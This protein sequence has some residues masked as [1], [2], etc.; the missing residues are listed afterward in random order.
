[1]GILIN[2]GF[3]VGSSNPIDS[4][5]L[6]ETTLER[7]ALISDGLV[8]ENLKVYCKDT[9]TEYRWTGTEWEISSSSSS[10]GTDI[11]MTDYYTKTEVDN[12]FLKK[13]D[14]ASTYATKTDIETMSSIILDSEVRLDKTYS[15]SKIYTDIQDAIDTSKAYTLSELGKMSGASYKVVTATSEMTDEKI[16]Y[17]LD[18]GTTF[19]MYIV[20]SGIPTKIGDTDID[21]SEYYTKTEVDNDFLKKTDASSIYATK[22][23]LNEKANDDEVVKK[24]D[25]TDLQEQTNDLQEQIDN[26]T[27]EAYQSNIIEGKVIDQTAIDKYGTEILKYPLGIWR[28]SSDSLS[29]KFSDLPVKTCGRIEITSI[30][31]DTNR[32]PWDNSYSYRVCNF[33]TCDWMNYFRKLISGNTAGVTHDTGWQKVCTTSVEDVP[34]SELTN[35]NTRL[36]QLETKRVYNSIGELNTAKG[37]SISLTNG[38]DNTMKII[39]AL[40]P[41]ETFADYFSNGIKDN[42]FGIDTNTY[43]YDISLLT[44]TKFND[45][46]T[47]IRAFMSNGKLLVRRYA[48]GVLGDWECDSTDLTEINT[49]LT[50]LE[51]TTTGKHM[52]TIDNTGEKEVKYF[53]IVNAPVNSSGYMV[54]MVGI[55]INTTASNEIFSLNKYINRY[56]YTYNRILTPIYSSSVNTVE[57]SESCYL[58]L[59]DD[60]ALYVAIGSYCLAEIEF[61]GT[62]G[63]L[64]KEEVDSLPTAEFTSYKQTSVT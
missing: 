24:A 58:V 5:T 10:S 14:A 21:L 64:I 32:N 23:E 37:L 40:S 4:R 38:E 54:S 3:D 52:I 39:D 63:K 1:M 8:Y 30:D 49:R 19:D 16:I 50:Q 2:T 33:E 53:K 29:Q 48:R 55:R 59:G 51:N 12:D 15:S 13:T 41:I 27:Q 46:I 56:K 62:S 45:N 61:I 28:I 35:I 9:Q 25:I 34:N 47:I 17:L 26:L 43:G 60:Y 7:D 20:E 22:T 6:K 42:R 44:I 57:P 36:T 11:S 18:N 31:S